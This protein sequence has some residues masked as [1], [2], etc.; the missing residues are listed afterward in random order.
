MPNARQFPDPVLPLGSG[1]AAARGPKAVVKGAALA[2]MAVVLAACS[3]DGPG[4]RVPVGGDV[5][6]TVQ[7]EALPEALQVRLDSANTAYRARDY[8][9]ALRHYGLLTRE[10]PGLA[11]GWYGVG[12]TQSALGNVEAAD[13][14]MMEVHRLAPEIPLQHPGTSAPPNPHAQPPSDPHASPPIRRQ[15]STGGS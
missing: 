14:A 10:A 7:V 8:D 3:G 12:M 5:S 2:T 6:E 11:A 13:S 4:D 1:V 9:E 15:G